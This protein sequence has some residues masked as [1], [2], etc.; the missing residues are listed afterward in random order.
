[1]STVFNPAIPASSAYRL[2]V[3]K[4]TKKNLTLGERLQEARKKAL[5]YKKKNRKNDRSFIQDEWGW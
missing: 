5:A 2:G 4:S 3:M 1:M